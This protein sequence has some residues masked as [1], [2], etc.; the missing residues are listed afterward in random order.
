MTSFLLEGPAAEPVT[1]AEAKAFLKLDSGDED[2]L[3][4]TLVTAARLHVEGATGRA[5]ISQSWRLVL[6]RWP[7]SRTIR[8]AV[9]PLIGL[10]A[11]TA[12]DE[13]GEP[14]TLPL[15]GVLWDA[16]ASPALVFLPPGFGATNPVRARRGIEIDFTAGYGTEPDDVPATLRQAMLTLIAYW[17][18]N[19]DTVVIAGSGAVIPAGLDL[20]LG[21][22]RSLRL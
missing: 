18:E 13:D 22:Y 14:E 4:S 10:T 8:L 21:P 5:L 16:T 7:V 9:G 6:D 19:R 1:L 12:Y 3:V 15:T 17:F 11:I 2:A 20:M